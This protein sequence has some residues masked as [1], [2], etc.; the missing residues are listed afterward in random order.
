MHHVL[1]VIIIYV[2]SCIINQLRPYLTC[3]PVSEKVLQLMC[4][5]HKREEY[6]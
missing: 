2:I 3:T 6:A 5:R 1:H 4:M